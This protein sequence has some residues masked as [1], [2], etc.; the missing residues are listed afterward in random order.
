M[1]IPSGGI[2]LNPGPV[3]ISQLSYSNVWNAFKTKGIHRIYLNVN[4]LLPKIDEFRYI[5]AGTNA[6][7]IKISESKFDETIL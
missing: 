3:Y 2:S 1:L 6:T 4:S 5:D 7:V